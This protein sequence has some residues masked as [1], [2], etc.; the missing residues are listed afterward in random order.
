MR[1]KSCMMLGGCLK[2]LSGLLGSS[3]A[4]MTHA[5]RGLSAFD[6]QGYGDVQLPLYSK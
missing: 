6:R 3:Y 4:L 5:G 2:P 1:I